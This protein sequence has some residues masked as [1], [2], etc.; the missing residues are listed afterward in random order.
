MLLSIQQ[1]IYSLQ[2]DN[3]NSL[4]YT[5]GIMLRV[6]T[7]S[8]I[9]KGFFGEQLTYFT[10]EEVEVGSIVEVPVRQKLTIALVTKAQLASDIKSALRRSDFAIKK[11]ARVINR[12]FFTPAFIQAAG[13]TAD[14]YAANLGAIIK[15]YT[16]QAVLDEMGEEKNDALIESENK[17]EGPAGKFKREDFVLQEADAE[18]ISFYKSLI[19][20]AFAKDQSVFCLLPT[21]AE[22]D[23]IVPELTRGIEEY[24]LILTNNLSKKE[25]L[26][27]LERSRDLSHP[28]L[29]IGTPLFLFLTR[30]DI[31]TLIVEREESDSYKSLQRPKSDARFMAQ[32]LARAAGWKIILGD[33]GLRA[34]TVFKT[35][36]MELTPISPLKYRAFLDLKQEIIA[37]GGREE[38]ELKKEWPA[39]SPTLLNYIKAALQ[40]G[41]RFFILSGRR[42]LSP[43]TV[44]NDCGLIKSC[45]FCERPLILHEKKNKKGEN[46]LICH[47]CGHEENKLD[48]CR[49]CG[50][51]RLTTLGTGIE[52]VE[53]ELKKAFKDAAVFKLDSDSVKTGKEAKAVVAQFMKK[54]GSLLLGTELALNYLTEP[55][56]N[57]AALALDSVLSAP[58]FRLNEK[59][60]LMLLRARSLASKRFV[61]E[62]RKPENK[63]YSLACQGNLLDFYREELEERQKLGWPPFST[64]IK[65]ETEGRRPAVD[66]LLE[67]TA[68]KLSGKVK[69]MDTLISPSGRAHFFNAAIILALPPKRWPDPNLLLAL[70]SL[71]P[72]WHIEVDPEKLF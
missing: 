70:R 13:E 51:W 17:P 45:E 40:N 21:A 68:K 10:K 7:V 58:D 4:L 54:P 43:T 31:K 65:V 69:N 29:I 30:P 32:A 14:Y 46:T 59:V 23:K 3:L 16:P 67:E 25:L 11:A 37:L 53:R 48:T 26:A 62:T 24:A 41:E 6:I 57:V 27:R 34:E 71:P 8:P 55:I 19:R 38:K 9:T 39:L 35:E 18:R 64:L 66:H 47:H 22:V 36:Q 50:S 5:W 2:V 1:T 44:C 60:F 52:K 72:N 33:L 20:E 49:N 63:I 56:P 42:G 28:L 15:T 12:Q 61:I